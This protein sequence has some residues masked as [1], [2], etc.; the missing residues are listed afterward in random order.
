[1]ALKDK[2]KKK[3][4]ENN[5]TLEEAANKLGVAKPTLQRYESGVISN[6]PSDKIEKLAEIYRTSPAFLMEWEDESGN[7]IPKKSR[8][9]KKKRE[10][11]GLTIQDVASH[12]SVSKEVVQ[13]LESGKTI[14]LR[15]RQIEDLTNL[16]GMRYDEIF[17]LKIP[18]TFLNAERQKEDEKAKMIAEYQLDAYEQAEYDK[19]MQMNF[20]MFEGR[21]VTDEEKEDMAELMKK[22]FVNSLLRNREDVEKEKNK[23]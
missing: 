14:K 18:E 2:L 4:L 20:L 15:K 19:I 9:L 1:M 13:E 12:I 5:L 17:T 22:I 11:L 23:K 21:K 3:R 6:I 7:L 10:S 8:N 16:L